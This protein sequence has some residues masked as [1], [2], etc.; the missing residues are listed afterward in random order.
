VH[1]TQWHSP[2]DLQLEH[3]LPDGQRTAGHPVHIACL[4]QLRQMLLVL[5]L[6]GHQLRRGR[7]GR[8]RHAAAWGGRQR[9]MK[10]SST[11][12]DD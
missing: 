3:C 4:L 7:A 8:E 5:L 12:E 6:R 2:T 1:T 10:E 9:R 11:Q